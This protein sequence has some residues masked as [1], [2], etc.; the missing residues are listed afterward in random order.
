MSKEGGQ[1]SSGKR[2][3]LGEHGKYSNIVSQIE[4]TI[5]NVVVSVVLMF[6]NCCW[7]CSSFPGL[8]GLLVRN[9]FPVIGVG[10]GR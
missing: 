6:W 2:S 4:R 10:L 9:L 7:G 3:S 8:L 1:G 5:L